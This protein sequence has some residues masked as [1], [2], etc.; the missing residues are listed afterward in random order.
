VFDIIP[1]QTGAASRL[2]FEPL[3]LCMNDSAAI[4]NEL[5][6]IPARRQSDRKG[7][8]SGTVSSNGMVGNPESRQTE[9]ELSHN[10]PSSRTKAVNNIQ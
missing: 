6:R 9:E 2:R 10:H 5:T 4:K 3:R 1:P 7:E 8:K